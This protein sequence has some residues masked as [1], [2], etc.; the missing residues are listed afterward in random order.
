M[1][2]VIT[3]PIINIFWLLAGCTLKTETSM[4]LVTLP[5]KSWPIFSYDCFLKEVDMIWACD[6]FI[7]FKDLTQNTPYSRQVL[8]IILKHGT[9]PGNHLIFLRSSLYKYFLCSL[10]CTLYWKCFQLRLTSPSSMGYRSLLWS[11]WVA[12][13]PKTLPAVVWLCH[14]ACFSWWVEINHWILFFLTQT[15]C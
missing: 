14:L 11:I 2:S 6:I 5:E 1:V 13:L 10:R 4:V 15:Q 7:L 12:L 9:K 8:T 3:E